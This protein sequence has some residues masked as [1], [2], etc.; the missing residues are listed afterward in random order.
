MNKSMDVAIEKRK[1]RLSGHTVRI[2]AGAIQKDVLDWNPQGARSSGRRRQTWRRIIEERIIET[3]K[4]WR[5]VK[6]LPNQRERWRPM[7]QSELK[8]LSQI[9]RERS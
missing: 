6:A 9:S 5:E 7:F 4:S 2:S 8:K 3:R 1:W